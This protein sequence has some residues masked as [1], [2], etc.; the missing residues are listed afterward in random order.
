[1]YAPSAETHLD[2]HEVTNQPP[3][4]A[5][6]DAFADD[7]ALR[8]A[9]EREGGAWVAEKAGALG[10]LV[11]DPQVQSLARQAN[12]HD[13]EHIPFDAFGRRLDHVEFHPAYHEL[14]RLAYG[15]AVHSLA[16]TER[17]PG[18]HVAR[19]ALS[20]LWNQIENGVGCPVGMTYSAIPALRLDPEIAALWEGPAL[21]TEYDPR[22]LPISQKTGATIGM[23]L[24]EKQGGSDLRANATRAEPDGDGGWRLTGH[25]YFCSAPMCD[26]FFTLA[27]TEQGLTCFIIPRSLPDGTR[28][29][30]FIQRLKDKCGNRSNASSEVEFN[31]TWAMRLG[32]E[33]AGIKAALLMTHHTRLDFAVASSG[34]MRLAL[35]HAL[36]HTSHRH[37]FQKFLIDQPLM[38]SVL[39]DLALEWE[40]AL[41]LSMR[42]ARAVDEEADSEEAR[43]FERLMTPVA[44]YWVCKRAPAFVAETLECMGGV[45]YVEELP[46]ARLYREAP[47]NGIWEGTGNVICLDIQRALQRAPGC[48]EVVLAELDRARGSEPRYDRFIDALRD[49]LPDLARD[50]ARARELAER[51]ACAL[52]AALLLRHAPAAVSDTFCRTRLEG[53]SGRHFG[54]LPTGTP[55]SAIVDRARNTA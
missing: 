38:T 5:G 51:L 27:A 8:E 55:T 37:A 28:N 3:P 21:S 24:T 42:V 6:I 44:K 16:W 46:M 48:D 53:A 40:A 10:K 19:A 54:V 23:T 25:K 32:E 47:L 50:Q 39:A 31:R 2:T 43:L 41:A 20:Y 22:P 52:Q 7:V 9:L 45:G 14:S 29:R 15:N 17:R 18:A 33:G 34:L 26:L 4:F 12:R 30:F 36:H 11:G 13:P 35:G 1:M 49:E